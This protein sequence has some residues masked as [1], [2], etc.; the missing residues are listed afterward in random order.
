MPKGWNGVIVP[1]GDGE[2]GPDCTYFMLLSNFVGN[3]ECTLKGICNRIG[4][5]VFTTRTTI[6]NTGSTAIFT[7]EQN[8]S[9]VNTLKFFINGSGLDAIQAK[10]DSTAI[11]LL[12]NVKGQNRIHITA[13]DQGKSMS[14][15]VILSNFVLKAYILNGELHVEE[16]EAFPS[17][18]QSSAI[19]AIGGLN[20]DDS[21]F[22]Y[23]LQGHR[24][25]EHFVSSVSPHPKGVYIV[26]GKKI[27]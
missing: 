17:E 12:N 2:Y 1:D 15:D 26:G 16:A 23:N 13:F 21:R 5:P 22:L 24:I 18:E 8:H 20:R 11:Y 3:Q 27:F 25:P 6:D 7:A 14:R 10:G 19:K 9:I 4:K